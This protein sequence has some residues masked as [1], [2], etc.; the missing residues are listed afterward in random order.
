MEQMVYQNE[1]ICKLLDLG[2]YENYEYFIL[3]LGTHPTAYVD[4][5]PAKFLKIGERKID[6]TVVGYELKTF[7]TEDISVHGGITYESYGLK[8][9]EGPLASDINFVIGW[10]YA[11]L[12]DQFGLDSPGIKWTTEVIREDVEDVIDQIIEI[13]G[14]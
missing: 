14:E 1:R 8:D 6:K 13:R 10:D 2:K 3:S 4:L 11:H 9:D 12:D 7:S 5:G